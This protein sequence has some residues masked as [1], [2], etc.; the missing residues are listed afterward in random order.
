MTN[1][2]N[3]VVVAFSGDSVG[4]FFSFDPGQRFVLTIIALGC[5]T[6]VIIS[7]AGMVSGLINSIHRRGVEQA[8]KRDML[9]RGMSAEEI[10]QVI[11]AAPPAEDALGRL[12]SSWRRKS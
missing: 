7:I 4:E 8:M 11:E 1:L 2:M 12:V 10:A 5:G 6:G 9:E 3:L